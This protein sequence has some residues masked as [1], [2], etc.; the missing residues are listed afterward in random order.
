M[1]FVIFERF[2]LLRGKRAEVPKDAGRTLCIGDCCKD[3]MN[4]KRVYHVPGCPP[5]P[6]DIIE[7][8]ARMK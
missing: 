7:T 3:L 4:D 8:I 2:D 6:E 1:Y 5:K